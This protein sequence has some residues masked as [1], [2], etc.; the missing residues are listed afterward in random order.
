MLFDELA[1]NVDVTLMYVTE[2]DATKGEEY[3]SKRPKLAK[4]WN[5]VDNGIN[6]SF[7]G[8]KNA[9]YVVFDGYTGVEKMKLLFKCILHKVPYTISV[10]VVTGTCEIVQRDKLT[11]DVIRIVVNGEELKNVVIKPG[12]V[13]EITNIG[14]E[15]AVVL[16]YCNE[17]FDP[18]FMDTIPEEV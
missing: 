9:D 12:Y 6:G 2:T 13:H 18:A 7:R 1:K 8:V 15:E 10:D 5:I 11:G 16:M 3:L 14:N 4:L 17:E